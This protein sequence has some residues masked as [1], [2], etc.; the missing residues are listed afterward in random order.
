[1]NNPMTIKATPNAEKVIIML[2]I[3]GT[4][5]HAG[6]LCCLNLEFFICSYSKSSSIID[7]LIV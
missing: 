7:S 3:V 6:S 4:G 2:N 5:R 1:M